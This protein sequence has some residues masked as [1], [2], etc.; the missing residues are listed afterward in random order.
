MGTFLFAW[1]PKK[2]DWKTLEE[3]IS[4]IKL[5]GSAKEE[6]SVASYRKIQ[7]G[8]RAFLM[9]L[10]KEPKG[11]M[12]AGFVSTMPFL[13]KHWSGEERDV[14]RIV[15]DFEVILNPVSEALFGLDKLNDGILA[16]LNWTPQSSGIEISK[17]A[18]AI[19][20]TKWF[21]FLAG[22][23]IYSNIQQETDIIRERVLTEGAP[24]Q[25]LLTRYE[26]NPY[27]RQECIN[28]YGLSCAVCDFNF[29]KIYG[30]IGRDFIHVHHLKRISSN[31]T[32]YDVSP[33]NDLRPV[34]PNCHA[35]LHKRVEPYTI[36]ELKEILRQSQYR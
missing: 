34:C 4:R 5:E 29:E 25:L 8:D 20:E 31:K 7:R 13:S 10:G 23:G 27:A 1:N 22:K 36:E 26:R 19:L 18:A 32:E 35:M 16:E 3:N 33:I 17:D 21:D 9:R 6:W 15:L 2:W 24:S 14:Y 28:Y 12:A 11:I 30:E